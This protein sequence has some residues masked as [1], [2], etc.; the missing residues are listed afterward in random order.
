MATGDFDTYYGTEPWSAIDIKE[1]DWYVPELQ[2]AF[3][4]ASNYS[5][6][7]PIKVDF[8]AL[9]TKKMIWTGLWGLEPDITAIG[10]R[11]IW[12]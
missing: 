10:A 3:R 6:M 12:A 11:D 9:R 5:Q 8:A 2:F 4:Q 7:V 1:R